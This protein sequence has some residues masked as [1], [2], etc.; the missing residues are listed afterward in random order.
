MIG[1]QTLE[2]LNRL[3]ACLSYIS[4]IGNSI[5]IEWRRIDEIFNEM[6]SKIE[7]IIFTNYWNINWASANKP[8]FFQSSYSACFHHSFI[9][10]W[11]NFQTT[12]KQWSTCI[13]FPSVGLEFEGY[14]IRGV[15][16]QMSCKV[17]LEG[18]LSHI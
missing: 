18:V 9:F 11:R 13:S 3:P 8:F 12:W 10:L 15:T 2:Y 4:L 1:S 6:Q 14:A 16:M 7:H 5:S 17:Y